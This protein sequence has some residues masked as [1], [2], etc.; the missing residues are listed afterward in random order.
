MKKLFSFALILLPCL[1]IA[2]CNGNKGN[3]GPSGG[4]AGLGV[5]VKDAKTIYEVPKNQYIDLSL[6]VVADPV[7]AEGYTIT[8]GA[9][10]NL[11]STYNAAQGTSY[12]MLPSSA[13]Q[14]TSAA[15]MLPRYATSSTSATLR[16]KGAGCEQ[17]KVYVLPVIIDNVS[18]GVNYEAPAEKAAYILFK[19]TEAE[20]QGSGTQSDPYI[21]EDADSFL[22]MGSLLQ[23]DMTIYFTQTADIDLS[24][25]HLQ[26]YPGTEDDPDT[27]VPTWTPANS[28]S[29]ANAARCAVFFEGNNHKI[30]NFKADA[31]MFAVLEGTVQNLII[32]NA[33]V[34]CGAA[35]V[36]G[37]LAGYAGPVTVEGATVGGPVTVKN[38][39]VIGSTLNDDY[40]RGGGLIGYITEGAIENCE[41]DCT[42][43]ATGAQMGGIAGRMEKGSILNCSTSGYITSDGYYLG[44]LVGYLGE[45]TI[46]DSHATGNITHAGAG[47]NHSGGLVGSITRSATIEKCYAT[48]NVTGT[49]HMIGGLVGDFQDATVEGIVVNINRSYATGDV[50]ADTG[51]NT[52]HAGGLVGSVNNAI[53]LNI[54]DCYATGKITIRRYSSGFLGFIYVGG[55]TVNIRNGFTTSDI[56]GIALKTHC[57]VVLGSGNAS[58]TATC[59]GFIAWNDQTYQNED[60]T[61]QYPFSYGDFLPVTG[62]YHG[63][64][65]TISQHA[66]DLGWS[67][68]IWDLSGD[69]PS[70]K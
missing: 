24:D 32:E 62:N 26:A 46:T 10:P 57:G 1:F 70:L 36:G 52:A 67:E 33:Q 20:Q 16:L 8:L 37:I 41:V 25:K 51:G 49:G 3:D 61:V 63:T 50:T 6:S 68:E 21:I 58:S 44:G 29:S 53:T 54:N 31:A 5:S 2:S 56:S 66:K 30:S 43:T 59:T 65:G 69:V 47:Y 34:D 17:D 28:G 35:N 18:G 9:N 11:V 7:S 64:S 22:K 60:Q 15:V 23:E 12:E 39:K 4:K 13:Y 19:M 14:F 38:V 45:V 27:Y 42:I 40:Q 55:A 48:G